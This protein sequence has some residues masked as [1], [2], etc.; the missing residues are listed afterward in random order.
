MM[1][2]ALKSKL[3]LAAWALIGSC[4]LLF[5]TDRAMADPVLV[6][7][8][9]DAT[10]INGLVVDG[11]TY[12]VTFVDGSYDTAFAG[13]TPTFANNLTGAQDAATALAAALNGPPPR[14]PAPWS[15]ST[16]HWPR[17]IAA[18]MSQTSG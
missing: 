16:S 18:A 4:A 17:P 13:S 2:I 6:G 11:I 14:L 5:V 1:T 10:G 8:T 9:T 15:I 3:A 12:D 7:T